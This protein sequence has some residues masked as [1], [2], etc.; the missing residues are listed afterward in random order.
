M[1]ELRKIEKEGNE[2]RITKMTKMNGNAWVPLVSVVDF[3]HARYILFSLD[4]EDSAN[5]GP[6]EDQR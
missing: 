3:N 6:T 2:T 4:G 1:N 5:N